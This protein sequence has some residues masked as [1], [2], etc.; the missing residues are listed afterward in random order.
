MPTCGAARPT[1]VRV[2]HRLVHG[3]DERGERRRRSRRPRVRAASARDRRTGGSGTCHRP[4]LPWRVG[5]PTPQRVR[6]ATDR[7]RPAGGPWPRAPPAGV[8]KRVAQRRRRRGLHQR[9]PAGA[10]LDGAQHRERQ[11]GPRPPAA[12][13]TAAGG[14]TDLGESP[15]GR[16]PEA[17]RRRSSRGRHEL[18]VAVTDRL[19]DLVIGQ[20]GLHEE[21]PAPPGAD[22][23][24]RARTR[25]QSACS[26]AR[27]PGGEE[28]LVGSRN[29][30]R[31]RRPGGTRWRTA[32]VPTS[33][34]PSG[35]SAVA[36]S[37]SAIVARGSSAARSSRRWRSRAHHLQRACRGS[38]GTPSGRR[39]RTAH[40]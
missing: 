23:A 17:L 34:R 9:P 26:A 33:T 32:S 19:D 13:S 36:A 29:A 35:I 16:V 10:G 1:P 37:T 39:S 12:A 6:P 25:S 28:L 21:R 40:T 31:P 27:A 2:V 38:G 22:A 7:R 30:T 5:R 20:P 4:R 8:A 3:V 14:A 18:R 11:V 15:E 24:A